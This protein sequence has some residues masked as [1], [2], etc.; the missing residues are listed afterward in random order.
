MKDL[1]ESIE[2]LGFSVSDYDTGELY[3][4]LHGNPAEQQQTLIDALGDTVTVRRWDDLTGSLAIIERSADIPARVLGC[5]G[6][7][8]DKNVHATSKKKADKK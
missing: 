7:D 5:A 6:G 4:A 8:A 3:V 1:I 2:K